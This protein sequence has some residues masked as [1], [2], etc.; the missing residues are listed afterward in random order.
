[1]ASSNHPI[2]ALTSDDS[3]AKKKPIDVIA[4][5]DLGIDENAGKISLVKLEATPERAGAK[6]IQGS[7]KEQVTELVKILKE[8]EKVI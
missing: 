5:S 1:M 7:V 6:M 2:L 4:I 8:N 3:G